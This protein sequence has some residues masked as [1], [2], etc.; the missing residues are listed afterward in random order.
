MAEELFTR[1]HRRRKLVLDNLYD[2]GNMLRKHL[3]PSPAALP[4]QEKR[5]KRW[6]KSVQGHLALGVYVSDGGSIWWRRKC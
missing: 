3:P 5:E 4:Q 6:T 1:T 2:T